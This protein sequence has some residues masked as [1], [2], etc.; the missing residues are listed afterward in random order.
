MSCT[1]R[2]FSAHSK[3]R[4]LELCKIMPKQKRKPTLTLQQ[5]TDRGAASSILRL[6]IEY[7]NAGVST[8]S[9]P[10]QAES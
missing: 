6:V 7:C 10:G 8:K 9:Q 5:R 3:R 2:K 4:V 1:E